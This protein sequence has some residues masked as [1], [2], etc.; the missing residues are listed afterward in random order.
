MNDPVIIG[1]CTHNKALMALDRDQEMVV[2]F[3]ALSFYRSK[4]IL[5][6]SKK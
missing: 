4:V 6:R 2:E 5:D 3:N 1:L